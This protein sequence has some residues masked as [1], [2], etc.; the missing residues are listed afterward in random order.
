MLE[1][2]PEPNPQCQWVVQPGP[3]SWYIR[4]PRL[5]YRTGAETIR[6][7]RYCAQHGKKVRALLAEEGLIPAQEV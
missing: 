1:F 4:E 2:I 5:C 7:Q 3:N 6:G